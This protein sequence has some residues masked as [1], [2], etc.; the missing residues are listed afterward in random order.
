MQNLKAVLTGDLIGSTKASQSSLDLSMA[1]LQSAVVPLSNYYRFDPRFTRYR[2]DG[3]QIYLE[4][5]GLVLRASLMMIAALRADGPGLETRISVGLGLVSQ[6]GSDG[7]AEAAG[8]AFIASGQSLDKMPSRK[9]LIISGQGI[10]TP[11]HQAIFDL[12]DW[13]SSRWSREQA[14]AVMLALDPR[15]ETQKD[16]AKTLNITRQAV[17]ARLSSAGYP[18]LTGAL[19]A[20]ERSE[21]REPPDA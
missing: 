12:V 9:R 15:D 2:G 14:K 20:F 4:H 16:L 19:L 17:Q 13:Q 5:P 10:A 8:S 21:Y 7:L 1:T 18:A 11:W 3:W 6:L